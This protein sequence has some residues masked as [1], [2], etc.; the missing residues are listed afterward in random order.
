MVETTPERRLARIVPLVCFCGGYE[1][2]ERSHQSVYRL[3]V[4]SLAR[5]S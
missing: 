1:R 3:Q 2:H 4:A 5:L